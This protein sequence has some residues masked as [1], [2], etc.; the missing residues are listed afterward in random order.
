MVEALGELV[1][2][3]PVLSVEGDDVSHLDAVI[4][5]HAMGGD[6]SAIEQVANVR[7]AHSKM[8]RE[9]LH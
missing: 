4:P 3:A 1:S 2:I 8:I 6:L 9:R 5:A 7:A